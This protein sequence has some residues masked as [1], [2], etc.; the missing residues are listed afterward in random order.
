MYYLQGIW[1][2][3]YG[4]FFEL[5]NFTEKI[6]HCLRLLAL[7]NKQEI[8]FSSPSL[9]YPFAAFSPLYLLYFSY[10]TPI[11]LLFTSYFK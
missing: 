1:R 11:Y 10:I 5:P 6:V 2:Q 4:F 8:P 7:P 3:S 9:H